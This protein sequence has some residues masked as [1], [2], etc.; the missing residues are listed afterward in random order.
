MT[1]EFGA[2]GVR[3]VVLAMGVSF[4]TSSPSAQTLSSNRSAASPAVNRQVQAIEGE[5]AALS[6]ETGVDIDRI[7]RIVAEIQ[8]TNRKQDAAI[9]S[10]ETDVAN[11]SELVRIWVDRIATV[12]AAIAA[13]APNPGD[14]AAFLV[15]VE[16]GRF[17]DA[18]RFYA[19][20]ERYTMRTYYQDY[21]AGIVAAL[22]NDKTATKDSIITMIEQY[23]AFYPAPDNHDEAEA[24]HASLIASRDEVL[25]LQRLQ[26]PWLAGSRQMTLPLF[27]NPVTELAFSPD[28]RLLAVGEAD[29]QVSLF[30][31]RNWQP[32]VRLR[33]HEGAVNSLHFSSDSRYLLTGGADSF[34]RIWLAANG[35][36]VQE[37]TGHREAV[38]SA[39]FSLD[40]D[41]V[42]TAS[43]DE[44]VLLWNVRNGVLVDT[45]VEETEC[46]RLDR[47]Q[48]GNLRR[49]D[50]CRF[51]AFFQPKRFAGFNAD[52]TRIL[53]QADSFAEQ[54][55][56]PSGAFSGRPAI[57]ATVAHRA[58]GPHRYAHSSNVYYAPG[59]LGGMGVL[60]DGA[61]NRKKCSLPYERGTGTALSADFARN[62]NLL[63]VGTSGNVVALYDSDDC[64]ALTQLTGSALPL[65]HIAISADGRSV[66]AAAGSRVMLWFD[67][68]QPVPADGTTS[69]A[70]RQ[71]N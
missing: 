23:I 18:M 71:S 8:R 36:K 29:G 55:E 16:Q 58:V 7:R 1:R 44:R 59:N 45:L 15:S 3:M 21:W 19:E 28:L 66:A 70:A 4:A 41:F 10:T 11:L 17:D 27:Q 24:L 63:A 26:T 40:D 68:S 50:G 49:D 12:E 54:Y 67:L 9:T 20:F 32:L 22:D 39:R 14:G 35:N 52:G 5:L 57:D 64:A 61:T 51:A 56:Y 48:A 6:R 43:S 33:A 34:A 69:S 2:W 30:N 25:R 13:G 53:V 62:A 38:N 46:K 47:E 60:I 42:V 31:I 65:K 37:F